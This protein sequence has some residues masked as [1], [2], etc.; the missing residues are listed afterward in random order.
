[1]TSGK[2]GRV[3]HSNT[4]LLPCIDLNSERWPR[5]PLA[6]SVRGPGEPSRSRNVSSRRWWW[7]C[8]VGAYS[9]LKSW[10]YVCPF[11]YIK[12]LPEHYYYYYYLG[13]RDFYFLLFFCPSLQW[14]LKVNCVVVYKLL[15]LSFSLIFVC[16]PSVNYVWYWVCQP[17]SLLSQALSKCQRCGHHWRATNLRWSLPLPLFKL[18]TPGTKRIDD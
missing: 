1:M 4:Y 17:H 9:E 10:F 2:T 5:R 13:P 11:L 8:G 12:T 7:W 15:F 3:F 18:N 14:H 6:C 16:K